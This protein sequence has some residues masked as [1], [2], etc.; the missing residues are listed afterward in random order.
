MVEKTVLDYIHT[1]IDTHTYIHTYIKINK[2]KKVFLFF[3][4]AL[5]VSLL[6]LLGH[7]KVCNNIINIASFS[8]VIVSFQG[9][10]MKSSNCSDT[11]TIK[12]PANIDN[13]K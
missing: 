8:K 7:R 12:E 3:A 2:K 6:R 11:V 4:F 1:Y 5:R 10:V 13:L 9:H